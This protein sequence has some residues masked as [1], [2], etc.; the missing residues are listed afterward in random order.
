MAT[1]DLFLISKNIIARKQ[2]LQV[3]NMPYDAGSIFIFYPQ[4]NR[5]VSC[6]KGINE[7]EMKKVSSFLHFRQNIL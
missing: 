6:P 5:S 3:T 4:P 2:I 7:R 1:N